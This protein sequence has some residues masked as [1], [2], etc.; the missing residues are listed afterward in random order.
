M[1]CTGISDCDRVDPQI[2]HAVQTVLTTHRPANRPT[3]S[4]EL[5]H[6]M[7]RDGWRFCK[8]FRHEATPVHALIYALLDPVAA[9]YAAD[10]IIA[11]TASGAVDL[12][13]FRATSNIVFWDDAPT[14]RGELAR[15]RRAARQ[16]VR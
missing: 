1:N 3:F 14:Y 10:D 15:I 12:R 7:A 5:A 6:I 2:L 11:T 4:L 9:N 8:C 16:A 13:S